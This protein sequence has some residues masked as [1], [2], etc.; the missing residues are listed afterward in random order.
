MLDHFSHLELACPAMD[1]VRLAA[2]FGE[3][4][5]RLLKTLRPTTTALAVVRECPACLFMATT[6]ASRVTVTSMT[7]AKARCAKHQTKGN[8][9]ERQS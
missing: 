6:S 4:L 2:G 8:L 5:V 9:D 1:Q 7:A 3:A